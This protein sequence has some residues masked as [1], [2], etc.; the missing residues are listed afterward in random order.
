MAETGATA[1]SENDELWRAVLTGEGSPLKHDRGRYRRYPGKPRCKTCLVPLG[2][3]FHPVVRVI[4]KRK[5][6]LKNPNYCDLCETFVRTHPGGAEIKLSL[7]F[8]DVRG[9]TSLAER[10]RPAEFTRLMNRFFDT[11]NRILIDSDAMVDKLVGDEVIGLYLP[12]LGPEHARRS[13]ESARNLLLATGHGDPDGPW[14]PVG[15]G[16]HTGVA[17]VGSVGS[18]DTV[19]DFSAMGDSVNVTARL[20]SLAGQGEVLVS[21]ASHLASGLDLGGLEIRELELKG[22]TAP[23]TVRVLR[24]PGNGWTLSNSG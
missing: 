21:E 1:Q 18:A 7:L 22:R 24:V 16:V 10:M 12:V 13:I 15:A 17:Y 2:G 8:A 5:P 20:A 14:L 23:L 4:T 3:S 6:S 11:S 9:S 19:A